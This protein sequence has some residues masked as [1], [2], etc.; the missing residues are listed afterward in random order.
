MCNQGILNVDKRM[1]LILVKY[2]LQ[3]DDLHA[4]AMPYDN[5]KL[6]QSFEQVLP[7]FE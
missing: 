5:H 3:G 4:E 6:P 1:Y 2:L 7:I